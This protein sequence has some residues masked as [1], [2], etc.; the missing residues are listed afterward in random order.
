MDGSV[1]ILRSHLKIIGTYPP[2]PR[3]SLRFVVGYACACEEGGNAD[4]FCEGLR[5][6]LREEWAVF[7]GVSDSIQNHQNSSCG[8]LSRK[9]C[10]LLYLGARVNE[11]LHHPLET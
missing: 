3:Y 2:S 1:A 9:P 10:S 11:V 7:H 5:E 8:H 6:E 4:R